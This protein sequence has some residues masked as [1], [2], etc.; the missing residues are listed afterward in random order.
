LGRNSCNWIEQ[1]DRHRQAG[2]H[3]EQTF[4]IPLLEGQQLRQ[5][6]AAGIDGVRHD[7]RAHLCAPNDP[8]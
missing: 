3:F 4:K 1:A 5:R 7:H 2:H 8:R 6:L